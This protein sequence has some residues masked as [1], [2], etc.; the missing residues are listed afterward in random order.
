MSIS[1]MAAPLL[2]VGEFHRPDG[3]PDETL[4]GRLRQ[5]G[6]LRAAIRYRNPETGDRHFCH[7]QQYRAVFASG[8]RVLHRLVRHMQAEA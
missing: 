5:L 6:A 2:Q 3:A 1:P 4:A 7:L 8:A